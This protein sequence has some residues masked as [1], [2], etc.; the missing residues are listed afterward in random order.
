MILKKMLALILALSLSIGFSVQS[1]A[2][3]EV[4]VVVGDS[5]CEHTW[6]HDIPNELSMLL[7]KAK[8]EGWKAANVSDTVCK[9]NIFTFLKDFKI[10]YKS[11][12][13]AYGDKMTDKAQLAEVITQVY[14]QMSKQ[15]AKAV[16]PKIS[17]EDKNFLSEVEQGIIKAINEERKTLGLSELKYDANLRKAARIRSKELYQSGVWA[18]TRVNGD[19]WQTVLRDDVPYKYR[20]AGENLAN[21]RYNDPSLYYHTDPS[22]WFEEWKSSET[23]YA[24][25]VLPEFTNIGVA[26][27]YIVDDD[28]MKT[29]YATTLFS[30][31]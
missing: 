1:F 13:K 12:M 17:E 8:L 18:H 5:I 16:A 11:F 28:G 15:P 25:I 3:D 23:H 31:P 19:P 26:V 20:S 14:P 9:I 27:Y 10:T 4:I 6:Q 2:Q 22:W 30:K 29:A 24:N 7:S 21:I